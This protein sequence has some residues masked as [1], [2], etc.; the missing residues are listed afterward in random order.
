MIELTEG[1]INAEQVTAAVESPRCGAVVLFLGT[2]RQ[3]TDAKETVTLTYTAYAPMAQSQMEKL[4]A[5]AKQRWPVEHCAIVHRLGEV[6][7]GEASVAVAVSS[8]HRRDA[9]EAASWLMDRLKELVP[10]WK[11]EH[12]AEGG[13]DWVHP[14]LSPPQDADGV[15]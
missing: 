10:V 13:T 6:P 9:F 1:Q 15:Q 7:I 5:Q 4:A 3:F 12:W 14:G 11:K 2:T 8:P